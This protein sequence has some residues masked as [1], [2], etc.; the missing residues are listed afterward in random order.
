MTEQHMPRQ[1]INP[2]G[3]HPAP[4][5]SH[6]AIGTGSRVAYIAGQTA[7]APDFSVIGAD[8]LRQQTV[9]ATKNVEICLKAIGAGW[10][11]VVRRTIFT[12]QPEQYGVI[13]SG[14]EEVQGTQEHPAQSII[15]VTGLAIPGL[16]IEI[17]VTVVMP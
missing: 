7:L 9:A 17:E 12:T 11:H 13:T 3:L 8:D 15:G 2:D 10:E 4:G 14:I 1:L 6:I 16:L 5:F